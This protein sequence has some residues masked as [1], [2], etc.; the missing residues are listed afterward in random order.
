MPVLLCTTGMTALYS[1]R[2]LGTNHMLLSE[3]SILINQLQ[4]VERIFTAYYRV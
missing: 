1:A 3:T 4:K 2:M